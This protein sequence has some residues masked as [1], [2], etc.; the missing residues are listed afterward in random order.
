MIFNGVWILY[1]LYAVLHIYISH[2]NTT[3][4]Q[5]RYVF[6]PYELIS[7]IFNFQENPEEKQEVD[8]FVNSLKSSM[9]NKMFSMLLKEAEKEAEDEH[10]LQ[11]NYRYVL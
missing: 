6:G 10:V 3:W 9:R 1:N 11:S 8:S 2:L 7:K 4:Y 5:H